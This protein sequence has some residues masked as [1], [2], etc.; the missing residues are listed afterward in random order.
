MPMF[1]QGFSLEEPTGS[2]PRN[3]AL[4]PAR[5]GLRT[6]VEGIGHQAEIKLGTCA[7]QVQPIEGVGRVLDVQAGV[8][9]R[10][11]PVDSRNAGAAGPV[12]RFAAGAQLLDGSRR[13]AIGLRDA[14]T[15]PA[16]ILVPGSAGVADGGKRHEE[17]TSRR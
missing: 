7:G 3:A 13:E 14:R 9:Q 1:L 10:I 11:D 6:P 4:L 17:K 15:S 5:G 2:R 8:L 16:T 12:A